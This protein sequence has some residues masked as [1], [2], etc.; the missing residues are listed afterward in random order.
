MTT[1]HNKYVINQK[2]EHFD[3]SFRKLFDSIKGFL[4]CLQNTLKQ[5]ILYLSTNKVL[6]LLLI[7]LLFI[8]GGE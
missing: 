5:G 8:W 1:K 4:V 2:L 6:L 7:C 3:A